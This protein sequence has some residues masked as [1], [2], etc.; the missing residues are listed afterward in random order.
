MAGL[1]G[2]CVCVC[3]CVRARARMLSYVQLFVTPWTVAPPGSSVPGIFPGKNTGELPFPPPGDLSD[4]G[5]KPLLCLLHWQMV[6]IPGSGRSPGEGKGFCAI[7]EADCVI[8]PQDLILN[9]NL[10]TE[11][12]LVK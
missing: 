6:L 10:Y 9:N 3:V 12:E 2:V 11:D 5:I 1:C 7:W 4:A 8:I